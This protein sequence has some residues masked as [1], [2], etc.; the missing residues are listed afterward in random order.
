MNEIITLPIMGALVGYGTNWLAIKMVFRPY[1]EKQIFGFRVPFTPGVMAKERYAFS[2]KLGDTLSENVIT[3]EELTKHLQKID[4]EQMVRN[5]IG[6]I[7]ANSTI[8]MFINDEKT[9]QAFQSEVKNFII[10]SAT[11]ESIERLSEAIVSAI[12]SG[13]SSENL[14]EVFAKNELAKT[15]K[16]F[17]NN[18]ELFRLTNNIISNFYRDE[19]LLSTPIRELLGEGVTIKIA[20][21]VNQNIDAIRVGLLQFVTSEN[22]DF[23]D[24]KV[25]SL[26]ASSIENIPLAGMFGG[27]GLAK[28]ITPVLKANTIEYLQNEENNAEIAEFI[29]EFLDGRLDSEAGKIAEI[30]SQEIAFTATQKI[31]VGICNTLA[32]NIENIQNNVDTSKLFESII[33]TL[34]DKIEIIVF[35]IIKSFLSDDKKLDELSNIVTDRILNYKFGAFASNMGDGAISVIAE[36]IGR[37]FNDNVSTILRSIN[38]SE[39]VENKVNSFEMAETERLVV[40]IM[41]KELKMITSLGGVLG[42]VIGCVSLFLL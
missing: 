31:I 12:K 39:I 42:F 35:N 11:D 22:F 16:G 9:V 26:I 10:S 28:S 29:Y 37:V 38:I 40:D 15:I 6:N 1:E 41:N 19:E 32:D 20:A 36:M 3:D 18:D 25:E 21:S 8:S 13:L 27:A 17:K 30:F 23:I 7:D 14:S 2:K 34:N 24:A 4:L 33:A 5:I